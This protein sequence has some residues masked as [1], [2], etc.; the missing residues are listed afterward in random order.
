MGLLVPGFGM[1]FLL[2]SMPEASLSQRL[3]TAH[4]R[5]KGPRTSA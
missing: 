2:R 5:G 4:V 1:E 3:C